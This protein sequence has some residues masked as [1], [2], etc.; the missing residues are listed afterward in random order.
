MLIQLIKIDD[1][2]IQYQIAVHDKMSG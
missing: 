2:P 1:P